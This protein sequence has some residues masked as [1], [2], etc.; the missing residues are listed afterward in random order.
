[1]REK[2]APLRQTLSIIIAGVGLR[3]GGGHPLGDRVCDTILTRRLPFS[4]NEWVRVNSAQWHNLGNDT[5]ERTRHWKLVM[6]R[7]CWPAFVFVCFCS[8]GY[9]AER[10]ENFYVFHVEI[11]FTLYFF[12]TLD[13]TTSD[14]PSLTLDKQRF[15][16][17][18]T[19]QNSCCLKLQET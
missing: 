2:F 7:K 1:M 4:R 18:S 3:R 8:G 6:T 11:V 5:C 13:L 12:N 15:G 16:I 10:Q 17:K 9:N 19:F 14:Q